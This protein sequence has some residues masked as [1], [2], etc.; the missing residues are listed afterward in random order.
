MEKPEENSQEEISKLEEGIRMIIY[1]WGNITAFLNSG[2]FSF[3][4]DTRAMQD[5]KL[6]IDCDEYNFETMSLREIIDTLV[7]ELT[8][9]IEETEN[10]GQQ[11]IEDFLW[12]YMFEILNVYIEVEENPD[13][14]FLAVASEINNLFVTLGK[15][16]DTVYNT[17]LKERKEIYDKIMKEVELRDKQV[18]VLEDVEEDEEDDDE[19]HHGE[20]EEEEEMGKDLFKKKEGGRKK[21]RRKNNGLYTLDEDAKGEQGS[22]DDEDGSDD[23]IPKP[24]FQMPTGGTWSKAG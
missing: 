11:E 1:T 2:D 13:N 9:F 22:D 18:R 8:L 5:I 12:V 19:H 14:E 4:V 15:E 17:I 7:K 10:I 3:R 23:D 20:N 24:T 21:K 16:D 6:L